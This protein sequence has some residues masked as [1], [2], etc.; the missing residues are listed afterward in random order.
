MVLVARV[1]V[2]LA[3]IADTALKPI[4]IFYNYQTFIAGILAFGGAWWTVRIIRRQITQ[5]GKQELERRRRRN[6]AARAIMPAALSALC[7]YS[8]KC[9]KILLPLLPPPEE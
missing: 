8:E 5:T 7:D 3:S 9:L 6:F 1:R 2:P 4:V